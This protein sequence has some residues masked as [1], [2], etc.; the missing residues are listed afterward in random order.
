MF[1]GIA[2]VSLSC[3]PSLKGSSY[4]EKANHL[5]FLAKATAFLGEKKK[6]EVLAQ[7]GVCFLEPMATV[8]AHG[9]C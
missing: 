9:G 4:N 7:T 2:I 8:G 1:L 6:I 3:L 5:N